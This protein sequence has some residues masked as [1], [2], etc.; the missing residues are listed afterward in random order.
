[1]TAFV[2]RGEAA[3]GWT[4][5]EPAE[6]S[7]VTRRTLVAIEAGTTNGR[8]DLWF[9]VAQAFGVEVDDLLEVPTRRRY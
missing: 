7:G 4:D 2:A 6:R 9:R 8:V 1:M 5:D 3:R